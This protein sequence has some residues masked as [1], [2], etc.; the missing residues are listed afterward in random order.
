MSNYSLLTKKYWAILHYCI[1]QPVTFKL[2]KS[3]SSN[4][5]IIWTSHSAQS[6]FLMLHWA[7]ATPNIFFFSGPISPIILLPLF[8]STSLSPSPSFLHSHYSYSC[9]ISVHHD[10]LWAPQPEWC[11]G[12]RG[13][14]SSLLRDPFNCHILLCFPTATNTI[15]LNNLVFV[16]RDVLRVLSSY[17]RISAGWVWW[18]K[19]SPLSFMFYRGSRVLEL[20]WIFMKNGHVNGPSYPRWMLSANHNFTEV[21]TCDLFNYINIWCLSGAFSF[22]KPCAFWQMNWPEVGLNAPYT[23]SRST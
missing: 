19:R 21:L 9:T 16:R 23:A 18:E 13:V 2:C 12:V 1:V 7:N 11:I 14:N 3:R 20:W 5:H 17:I 22:R 8:L 10:E 6:E 15:S 4:T